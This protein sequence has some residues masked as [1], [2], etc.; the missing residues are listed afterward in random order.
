MVKSFYI[1]GGW[2]FA[3]RSGKAERKVEGGGRLDKG[4][5]MGLWMPQDFVDLGDLGGEE[6]ATMEGCEVRQG[7]ILEKQGF[8]FQPGGLGLNE[9]E[10]ALG[11]FGATHR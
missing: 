10:I 3:E 5:K 11:E 2:F 9:G 7:W 4:Q 8:E 6:G 1:F